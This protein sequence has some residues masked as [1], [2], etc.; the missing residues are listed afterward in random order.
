MKC[1]FCKTL[2]TNVKD[3]RETDGGSII[4]RRRECGECK[5]RFTTFEKVQLRE[6]M[7]IKRSGLKRPFDR[8]K[9]FKSIT[10]ALRKR[11]FSNEDIEK[12][13]NKIC[14]ELENANDKEIQSKTI[15]KIIMQ[16]LAIIDQVAYVRFA[17]V[18]KDFTTIQDFI[19][20]I[21]NIKKG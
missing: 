2:D 6:I 10:T 9:I 4:R 19:K 7:V 1:P 20:F 5:K 13:V 11:N 14:L 12:F 3:S 17:S 8:S 15:G 16:E 18:Y 21:S